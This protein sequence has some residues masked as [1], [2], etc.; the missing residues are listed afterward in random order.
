M[1]AFDLVA[2]DGWKDIFLVETE[3]ILRAEAGDMNVCSHSTV[4]ANQ[5]VSPL[6]QVQFCNA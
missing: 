4:L 3:V 5:G 2:G 1:S 6:I